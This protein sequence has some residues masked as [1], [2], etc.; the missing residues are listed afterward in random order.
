MR[1]VLLTGAALLPAC[2]LAACAARAP[3]LGDD[4][5]ARLPTGATLL[6]AD[7]DECAGIVELGRG[8]RSR[9]DAQVSPG[10][11]ATFRVTNQDIVWTCLDRTLPD[12]ETM[13]CPADTE[14][15]RIT[16][17]AGGDD[18]LFECFG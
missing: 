8:V 11:N 15:V 12:S 4:T 2:V 14:Y 1:N 16:R 10:Q 7:D 6:R 17:S 18:V 9:G 3:G 13:E 5:G